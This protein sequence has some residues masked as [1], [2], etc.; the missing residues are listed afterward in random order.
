MPYA[1][2]AWWNGWPSG[3]VTRYKKNYLS[4]DAWMNQSVYILM[5]YPLMNLTLTMMML[6]PLEFDGERDLEGTTGLNWLDTWPPEM[7]NIEYGRKEKNTK[8]MQ[9]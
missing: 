7:S 8:F 1:I 3:K 5:P 6:D 4:L 9:N 2:D